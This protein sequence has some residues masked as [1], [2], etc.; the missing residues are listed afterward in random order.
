[1]EWNVVSIKKTTEGNKA[2]FASIGRGSVNFNAAACE[3][4]GDYNKFKYAQFLTAKGK[5]G[6]LI[7]GVKFLEEHEDN[8]I[9]ISRKKYSDGKLVS[10]MTIS[11]KGAVKEVFGAKG[12][13]KGT[14]RHSVSYEGDNIL[15]ISLD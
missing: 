2:P 5:N 1:M 13:I 14:E 3:L 7:V 9:E 12:V 15:I 6:K 11:H 4:L 10:G 8:S